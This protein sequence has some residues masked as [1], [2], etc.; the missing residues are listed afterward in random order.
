MARFCDEVAGKC[1]EVWE[2]GEGG[3]GKDLVDRVAEEAG[4]CCVPKKKI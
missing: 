3:V 1:G 4:D 2:E